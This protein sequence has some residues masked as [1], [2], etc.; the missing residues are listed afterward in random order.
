MIFCCAILFLA[1]VAAILGF[2][3]KHDVYAEGTVTG[4]WTPTE[5]AAGTMTVT[6]TAAGG[7]AKVSYDVI[8]ATELLYEEQSQNAVTIDVTGFNH[9]TDTAIS[10]KYDTNTIDVGDMLLYAKTQ[11]RIVLI[12]F[13]TGWN[14]TAGMTKD[15][16]SYVTVTSMGT[17]VRFSE[18]ENIIGLQLSME[19][20]ET[21]VQ[22]ETTHSISL[23]GVCFHATNTV[24]VF[25]TDPQEP[26][27]GSLD[28]ESGSTRYTKLGDELFRYEGKGNQA[29]EMS[30][31]GW[32][33]IYRVIRFTAQARVGTKLS[34]YV[35]DTRLEDYNNRDGIFDT[36]SARVLYFTVP[37]ET[38]SVSKLRLVFDPDETGYVANSGPTM[39][40]VTNVRF[41]VNFH[42]GKLI[43]G[44]SISASTQDGVTTLKFVGESWDNLVQIPLSGWNPTY[45]AFAITMKA[46]SGMMLGISIQEGSNYLYLRNHYDPASIVDSDEEVT[47]IYYGLDKLGVDIGAIQLWLDPP[48]G[49]TAEPF[50]GE[51]TVVISDVIILRTALLPEPVVE[52]ESRSVDYNGEP[53]GIVGATC[54]PDKPL[55]YYYKLENQPD[56]AYTTV[57]PT[58]GGVYTVKVGFD[59]D[60]EYRAAYVYVTLTI[61]RVA[62][63]VPSEDI[64]ELD[65]FSAAIMFNERLV[66]VC[67]QS[68]FG[69]L[70]SNNTPFVEGE[71]LYAR[72]K[73]TSNYFT[74]D[75]ITIQ[76]PVRSDVVLTMD[77]AQYVYD[78]TGRTLTAVSSPEGRPI[79]YDYKL[80]SEGDDEYTQTA[81][82]DAGVYTVRATFVGTKD[83]R[84]AF[85]TATLTIERAKAATPVFGNITINYTTEKFTF[86]ASI[87]QVSRSETFEAID[88]YA[89][90]S[91]VPKGETVYMKRIEDN[92]YTESDVAMLVMP[93]AG[94][95]APEIGIDFTN[96]TTSVA[97]TAQIEY[98]LGT[99]GSWTKGVGNA[100]TLAADSTYQFR[101]APTLSEFASSAMTLSVPKR[102]AKPATVALESA[103]QDSITVVKADGWEYRLGDDGVWQDSNVFTD[104]E[105]NTEYKVFARVKATDTKYASEENSAFLSTAA[106]E[107]KGGCKGEILTVIILIAV[108]V[109]VAGTAFLV[110]TKVKDKKKMPEAQETQEIQEKDKEEK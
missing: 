17:Y 47:Y 69:V 89:S 45:D 105:G 93:I 95:P 107:R 33:E 67:R 27:I 63:P 35:D 87:Y 24:P 12:A 43:V 72:N 11:D 15:G 101:Y 46:R 18:G 23:L 66:E 108:L 52:A 3:V 53:H 82:C 90:G 75:A 99:V 85:I 59:G 44:A 110:W 38:S 1:C 34:V 102:A 4:V 106:P 109:I 54:T 98:R 49:M 65:Y 61:N 80:A 28:N 10:I 77:G 60:L 68:D 36:D 14:T 22:L 7:V 103:T 97:I 37:E 26:E 58:N 56:S 86:D 30:I 83:E 31:T 29:L 16:Y 20:S 5:E 2:P 74:S 78:G 64:V 39:V 71:T 73:E 32:S 6:D 79:I 76:V 8:P 40:G 41:E 62:A 50:T 48:T 104:L 21:R 94:K 70:L 55:S 42:I 51:T 92:N 100:V 19:S 84:T 88:L 96:E 57:A 9:T 13:L 25:V 81:P 91:P